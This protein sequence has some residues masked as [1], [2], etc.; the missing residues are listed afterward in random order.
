MDVY[1]PTFI[2]ERSKV[3]INYLGFNN[4]KHCFAWEI[5]SCSTMIIQNTMN[6]TFAEVGS[7]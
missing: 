3:I 4:D 2:D 7:N 1:A 6:I 5:R